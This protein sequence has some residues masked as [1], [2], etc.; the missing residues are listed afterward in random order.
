[1][2]IREGK[3]VFSRLV[4]GVTCPVIRLDESHK[5]DAAGSGSRY[6]QILNRTVWRDHL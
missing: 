5:L 3:P 4:E 6:V 1:M 2:H